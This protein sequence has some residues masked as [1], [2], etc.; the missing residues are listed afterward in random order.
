MKGEIRVHQGPWGLVT[1][2]RII[3]ASRTYTPVCE[4]EAM[5]LTR[6]K[7]HGLASGYE[8]HELVLEIAHPIPPFCFF[9]QGHK[10][11]YPESTVRTTRPDLCLVKDQSVLFTELK[12]TLCKSALQKVW[13]LIAGRDAVKDYQIDFILVFLADRLIYSSL[14]TRQVREILARIGEKPDSWDIRSADALLGRIAESFPRRY[15]QDAF[16]KFNYEAEPIAS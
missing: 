6:M 7:E 8:T 2:G 5:W 16:G 10:E 15:P 1:E 12:G 9:H 11:R 13:K 3:P 4:E 14:K